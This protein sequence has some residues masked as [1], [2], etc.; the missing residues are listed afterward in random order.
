MNISTVSVFFY[1]A[2]KSLYK[3]RWIWHT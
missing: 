1:F 2:D 3:H